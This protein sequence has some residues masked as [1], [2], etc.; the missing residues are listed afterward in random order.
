MVKRT[1]ALY[2]GSIIG[3]ESIYSVVDGKQINKPNELKALREKSRN[4]LLSCPCGCGTILILVAG[5][6]NLREQH[7]REKA[8]TGKYECTMPTE[9]EKSISSKIVLKCWLEDKLKV[10]DIESRVPINS[11]E[12]TIRK[13]EYTF[14]SKSKKIAIRYWMTRANIDEDKLDVLSSTI[15]N[16][17]V[18]YIVDCSNRGTNGQYPETLMKIQNKQ[19]YCLYLK[20]NGID[21]SESYLSAVYFDKDEDGL[22]KEIEIDSAKLIDVNIINDKITFKGQYLDENLKLKKIEFDEHKK[23]IIAKR[24]EQEKIEEERKRITEEKRKLDFEITIKRLEEEKAKRLEEENRKHLLEERSRRIE[25]EEKVRISENAKLNRMLELSREKVERRDI[26]KQLQQQ[27]VQARDSE[28][29][30]WIKCEC[31]GKIAKESEFKSYGG[32]NHVNLGICYDCKINPKAD[33]ILKVEKPIENKKFNHNT[34]PECGGKLVLRKGK[35][36]EFYGCS[37]YPRCNFS[38]KLIKN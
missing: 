21:Y 7:F 10:D 29:N 4:N 2:N 1:T 27:E 20:I 33:E 38:K 13:P 8:G 9:S 24:R 36:G 30:R 23:L 37:N 25:E 26:I 3:I 32:I 16:I 5:E 34:C 14:L 18:I 28:G 17:N 12:N 19:G 15:N 6:K 31:C 35:F 22:W 11:F